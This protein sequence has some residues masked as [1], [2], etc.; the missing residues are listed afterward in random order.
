MVRVQAQMRAAWLR[1]QTCVSSATMASSTV[2]QLPTTGEVVYV[3][4]LSWFIGNVTE[5]RA[6][7]GTSCKR[8][9]VKG[10]VKLVDEKKHAA[11][12]SFPARL[13]SHWRKAS[14]FHSKYVFKASQVRHMVELTRELFF[15]KEKET[16]LA[17]ASK[18]F[19]TMEQMLVC[20][21]VVLDPYE[22]EEAG[23]YIDAS[24]TTKSKHV[25]NSCLPRHLLLTRRAPQKEAQRQQLCN[26]LSISTP[27]HSS[28]ASFMS[29]FTNSNRS[30]NLSLNPVLL[31]SSDAHCRFV[32]EKSVLQHCVIPFMRDA[33][34]K[35]SVSE[36]GRFEFHTLDAE[37][38]KRVISEEFNPLNRPTMR[39]VYYV[40]GPLTWQTHL[41]HWNLQGLGLLQNPRQPNIDAHTVKSSAQKEIGPMFPNCAI[42]KQSAANLIEKHR[43]GNTWLGFD[44]FYEVLVGDPHQLTFSFSPAHTHLDNMH[45]TL[46]YHVKHTNVVFEPGQPITFNVTFG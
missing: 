24:P 33:G 46:S 22:A 5:F 37:V 8:Y 2:F 9:F 3:S 18:A 43:F 14:Y 19:E 21:A 32:I 11:L 15:E 35:E 45:V 36:N 31:K 41:Q 40:P 17:N 6:L 28:R 27:L 7:Y 12:I 39:R 26:I 23:D 29:F 10:Y 13:E 20:G 4:L 38:A 44:H 1:M 34:F 16:A 42:S 30:M 25:R